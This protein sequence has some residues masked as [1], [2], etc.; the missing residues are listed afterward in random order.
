M[1]KNTLKKIITGVLTGVLALSLTACG[2][3]SEKAEEKA[4]ANSNA[5]VEASEG[6]A[7]S[8]SEN[9]KI[10]HAVTGGSPKPYI[11]IDEDGNYSG[12]DIEV[13]QA[14]FDR[15]PQYELDLQTAEFDAI[16][17][18][19]TAGNYQIA[20]N[21]FSYREERAE[22]YYYSY[23]YDDIKYVFIQRK[24]DEP[25][26][27]LKDAAE[28]GYKIE[29]GA[30]VNVTNAIE[31][32]NAENPDS[33]IEIIYT[34]ADLSVVFEHIQDGTSDFRIDD[35]PIYKSYVDEFNFDGLQSNELSAEETAKIATALDAYFLFPKTE[36]GAALR[37]DV[38]RVLKELRE[39]GTLSELSQKYF[40]ADQVPAAEKFEKTIN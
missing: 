10:I 14:V 30:G 27:S 21:N 20:V 32:W 37:E 36:E 33:Q 3:G 35:L 6:T 4:N 22:S 23:P 16:F 1:R 19:L 2:K 15:L 18:G 28:R 39:D 13:L 40:G 24:G 25:L 34:E 38:N 11:T 31:Q 8:N 17:A 12:Y 7:G 9:V 26:T 5:S 29:A